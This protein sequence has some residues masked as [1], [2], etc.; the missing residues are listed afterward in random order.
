MSALR[1]L[2]V[3]LA[4]GLGGGLLLPGA[5]RAEVAV[6][7]LKA[8][9]TDLTGTL[10]AAD[11]AAIERKLAAFEQAK[12][13]QIAVLILPTTE[14]ETIEQYAI[15]VAEQWKLG[16]E[17]VDDGAILLLAKEDRRLRIEVG[18]GLEGVLPD[19]V[20]K[21]IISETITPYLRRGDF[22]G[23]IDAGVTQMIGLVNGEVLP[24]APQK[25]RRQQR[26]G[27]S[28]IAGL[29]VPFFIVWF[30]GQAIRRLLGS[31]VASLAVGGVTGFIAFVLLASIGLGLLVGFI[32]AIAA[33]VLYSGG[34]GRGGGGF[35]MGGLGGGGS[36]GG[37]LGGGGFSGG[38]GFGGGGA[39][40][41]W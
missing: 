1:A 16:R 19:A 22:A 20:S 26:S 11:A 33:F 34:G 27:D 6:P 29:L 40:G 14:P 35:Y 8:R 31:G 41:N 13:S 37:G 17:G 28:R 7:P 4:L 3:W 24:P 9:V 5:A 2:A 10:P 25:Q 32:A 23:G 18:Y 38:G 21:R 12:G 39:S 15:R 30:I 36:F